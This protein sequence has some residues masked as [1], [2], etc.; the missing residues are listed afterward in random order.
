MPAEDQSKC[1]AGK[2]LKERSRIVMKKKLPETWNELLGTS[3]EYFLFSAA[4]FEVETAAS[5]QEQF[6]QAL[7]LQ[8]VFIW[9]AA[10]ESC[11][12]SLWLVSFSEHRGKKSLQKGT[13]L[14]RN[15]IPP[16]LKSIEH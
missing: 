2:A 14:Q 9:L 12:D 8:C 16:G 7:S 3:K 11:R 10:G 6:H 1:P 5:P 15:Y 13:A 4:R